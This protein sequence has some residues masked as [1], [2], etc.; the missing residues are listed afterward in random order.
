MAND[1]LVT[2]LKASVDNNDLFKL[3]EFKIK[4]VYS[5]SGITETNCA[6][7]FKTCT[8]RTNK[9]GYFATSFAGLNEPS[10]RLTELTVINEQRLY[11]SNGDYDIIIGD[12]Y[13]IYELYMPD[14][15][16]LKRVDLA[17]L[18][19]CTKLWN[20]SARNAA[21]GDIANF[22]GCTQLGALVLSNNNEVYGDIAAFA[23][24]PI[25]N[26]QL[27]NCI[28]VYGNVSALANISR[29]IFK[30]DLY[31]CQLTGTTQQIADM[32]SSYNMDMNVQFGEAPGITGNIVALAS[33]TKFNS[34]Y[35]C[36]T[37]VTGVID[38]L[39]E[40]LRPYKAS[41]DR[42]TFSFERTQVKHHETDTEPI[43]QSITVTF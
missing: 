30:L 10:S 37:G 13:N 8:V 1:C 36:G 41:G 7:D 12:K 25:F 32:F 23:N 22:S 35:F 34:F 16:P 4:N 39:I 29:T 26:L 9:G 17:D 14:N 2:K 19:Y 31:G 40:A 27:R 15:Y 20:V 21:Q 42:V 5:A 28:G 33:M 24:K 38:E 6:I 18:K 11:F 3:G 43:S